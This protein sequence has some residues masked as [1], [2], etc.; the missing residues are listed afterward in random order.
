VLFSA[1]AWPGLRDGSITVTFRS[2]GRAQVKVGGIYR[3][4]P[5]TALQVDAVAQVPVSSITDAD[6]QAAGEAD[7]AAL[8][9]R[10]GT[11]DD[12]A[13]V[14][15]VDFHLVDAPDPRVALRAD[16]DLDDRSRAELERR[17]DRLDRASPRGPWTRDTLAAI[18]DQPGVVSTVLAEQLG[19]DRPSFKLDV[20]KLKALGLT[21][22]LEVGYRLSPRGKAYL[23][24][25]GGGDG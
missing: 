25:L 18:R 4:V 20:R 15:R 10:L 11:P 1:K 24:V 13:L 14:W 3:R 5:E 17:L 6:A 9:R 22:S 16:D 21:E 2:W 23:R 19:R 7:R 12:T 8:L